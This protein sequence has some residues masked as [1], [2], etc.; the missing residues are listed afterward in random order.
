LEAVFDREKDGWMGRRMADREKGG[1]KVYGESY[2][3]A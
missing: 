2:S 1:C 3:V